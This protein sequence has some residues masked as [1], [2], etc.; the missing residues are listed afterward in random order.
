MVTPNP[1]DTNPLPSIIILPTTS[2]NHS[3]FPLYWI[4]AESV[5]SISLHGRRKLQLRPLLLDLSHNL[6]GLFFVLPHDLERVDNLEYI[7]T[8][9]KTSAMMLFRAL[10]LFLM[11][12]TA[13]VTA[14]TS[15][16]VNASDP[17]L[18]TR[19]VS[20]PEDHEV[21]PGHIR[22][23]PLGRDGSRTITYCF[24]NVDS[25]QG[26]HH[27]F[28][29]GLAKWEPAMRLSALKFAPDPACQQEPC[30]C[31]EPDVDE[32]TLH[33]FLS[34]EHPSAW[35]PQGYRGPDVDV[36]ADEF[37][38][39]LRWPTNK[40]SFNGPL[41]PLLMA[42]EI[43]RYLYRQPYKTIDWGIVRLDGLLTESQVTFSDSV[44]SMNVL[45][46]SIMWCSTAA[47]WSNTR[48]PR[49]SLSSFN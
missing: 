47:I 38:N 1:L 49:R 44:T 17:E 43:G 35:G 22:P 19:W 13:C 23:W 8:C 20:I 12:I 7:W 42:H 11:L 18:T 25:Y 30:L 34:G 16:R 36:G 39:F 15:P 6:G 21:A 24:E 9:W 48:K 27:I 31:D 26:L 3:Q 40:S 29:L 45:M 41:S 5:P 4:P 46:H 2:I 10:A 37:R 32:G 14:P 28:E 33:I